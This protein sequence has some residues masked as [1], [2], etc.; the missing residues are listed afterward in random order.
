MQN[1]I[2]FDPVFANYIQFTTMIFPYA[3]NDV[4]PGT[5][6][7]L[8]S[9]INTYAPSGFMPSWECNM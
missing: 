9:M 4:L 1:Q 7:P 2:T 8:Y 5:A 3:Y 6:S